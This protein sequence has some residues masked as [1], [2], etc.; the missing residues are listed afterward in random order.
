MDTYRPRGP[1]NDLTLARQL[2]KP[3]AVFLERGVHR[4]HLLDVADKTRKQIFPLRARQLG[5]RCCGRDAAFPISRIRRLTK[6]GSNPIC[7]IRIEQKPTNLGRL[8]EANRQHAGSG[9][10]QA[11]R[12]P[13]FFRLQ[14]ALDPL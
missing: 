10:V 5:D 7:L 6:P 1:F 3:L 14:Q 4:R 11:A 12:M 8:A 9:R 13:G 2:I